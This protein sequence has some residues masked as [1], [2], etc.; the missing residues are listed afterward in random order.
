M[1]PLTDIDK[2]F[3]DILDNQMTF[4]EAREKYYI[5]KIDDFFREFEALS[6]EWDSCIDISFDT[7]VSDGSP[8]SEWE[9]VNKAESEFCEEVE[10]VSMLAIISSDYRIEP[11]EL[12]LYGNQPDICNDEGISDYFRDIMPS[13]ITCEGSVEIRDDVDRYHD[14]YRES[15][16]VDLEGGPDAYKYCREIYEFNENRIKEIHK[17]ALAQGIENKITDFLK[18]CTKEIDVERQGNHIKT[19]NK[20]DRQERL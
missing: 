13:H 19:A 17:K 2:A 12:F 10:E 11:M 18:K 15:V 5:I 9:A 8:S 7:Y 6:P 14:E 1:M 3:D 16:E 4:E 20:D